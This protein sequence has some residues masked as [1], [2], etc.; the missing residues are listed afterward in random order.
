MKTHKDIQDKIDNTLKS[1]DTIEAVSVSPFFKDK[2]MNRLFVKQE[3]PVLL[4]W[5]TPRLQ[6]AILVCFVILNIV[7]FSEMKANNYDENVNEF[8]ETYG[9]IVTNEFVFKIN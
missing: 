2:T 3:E 1:V 8:G 9:L 7:A 4:N 5:F 6:L